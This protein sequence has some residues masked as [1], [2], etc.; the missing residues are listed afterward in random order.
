[1]VSKT[2]KTQRKKAARGKDYVPEAVK[3][4]RALPKPKKNM[5]Q[6]KKWRVLGLAPTPGVYDNF[7]DR[8]KESFECEKCGKV[9]KVVGFCVRCAVKDSEKGKDAMKS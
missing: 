2:L 1:M 3:P 6:K 9:G 7:E 4:E 8:G 5:T